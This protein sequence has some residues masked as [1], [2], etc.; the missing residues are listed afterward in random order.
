[1]PGVQVE[2]INEATNT[3]TRFIASAAPARTRR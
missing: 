1:M 2:V 3:T